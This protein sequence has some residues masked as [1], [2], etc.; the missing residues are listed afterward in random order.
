MTDQDT[1]MISNDQWPAT[2]CNT[3]YLCSLLHWNWKM[4]I[5]KVIEKFWYF[6]TN[7]KWC[8][9]WICAMM[10]DFVLFPFV[11]FTF[12]IK[13]WEFS[14][15]K[16][17]EILYYFLIKKRHGVRFEYVPWKMSGFV[18]FLLFGFTL[19]MK[20]KIFDFESQW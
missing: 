2:I 14:I 18:S 5:I 8:Q 13:L 19:V 4:L 1:Q 16:V 15:L 6:I 20:L 3:A 7:E 10:S 17:T 12:A 11:E 9:I